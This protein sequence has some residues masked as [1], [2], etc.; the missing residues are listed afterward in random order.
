[1]GYIRHHAIVVTSFDDKISTVWLKAK[2]MFGYLVSDVI[3]SE[4]NGYASFFI[5]P[6]GSKEGWDRSIEH[7]KLR[8]QFIAY[9]KKIDLVVDWVEV[10]YGDDDHHTMVVR[11]S[12]EKF[13]RETWGRYSREKFMSM[14]H[15][16][17][18]L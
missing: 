18:R 16:R 6:D 5:A 8:D 7:D 11:D 4:C 12:D 14:Y 17:A 1:M 10:Q 3:E 2:E 15:E 13:R 9:L